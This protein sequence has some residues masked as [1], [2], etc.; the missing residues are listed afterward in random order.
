MD[1]NIDNTMYIAEQ[2]FCNPPKSK[3]SIDLQL[4]EET[5]NIANDLSTNK[6]MFIQNIIASITF[7]GVYF[8]Y[9]HRNILSLTESQF[10]KINEYVESYGYTIIKKIVDNN[11]IIKF[12]KIY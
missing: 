8:L 10:Y 4:E 3:N 6:D 12:K 11:L 2:I 7:H 5:E 9:G 1:E